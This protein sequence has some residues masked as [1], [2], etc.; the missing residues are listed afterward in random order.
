MRRSRLSKKK[1]E[2]LLEHFIADTTA[3]CASS[4]VGVNKTTAAY[5]FQRLREIIAHHIEQ[6]S[7]EVFEGKL[8]ID[9]SYFGGTR[10]GRRGRGA[11]GKI[12]VFGLLKREGK[13]LYKDY[14]RCVFIQCD[15]YHK[16]QSN[17]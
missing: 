3:R 6:E 8:E 15:A 11:K 13:S 14:S 16:A 1:Q 4:L 9:E 12:P 5:Y 7:Q 17:S 2:K 10:K